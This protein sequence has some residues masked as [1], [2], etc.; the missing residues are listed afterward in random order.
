[1]KQLLM[2]PKALHRLHITRIKGVTHLVL[3]IP[4]VSGFCIWRLA[5]GT[6][7]LPSTPNT[8]D[9]RAEHGEKMRTL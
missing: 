7:D 6:H 9:S 4:E 5:E 3:L 8:L 2:T 1:M